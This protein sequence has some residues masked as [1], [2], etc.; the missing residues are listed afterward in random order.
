ML[1]CIIVD[2]GV[3][4]I[5]ILRKYLGRTPEMTLQEAF[6]DP[7]RAL[8]HLNSGRLPDLIFLDQEMPDVSGMEF[9]Q[10]MPKKETLSLIIFTTGHTGWR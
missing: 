10:I 6:T 9:V 3:E 4:S 1:R 8:E 2:D 5:N 7:L